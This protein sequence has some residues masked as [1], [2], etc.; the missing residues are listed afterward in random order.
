[1]LRELFI[2]SLAESFLVVNFRFYYEANRI[3]SLPMPNGHGELS[4]HGD[5]D[6]LTFFLGD[7]THCHFSQE[8][9]G[10]GKYSP[11]AEL[12]EEAIEFLRDLFSD[13][14]VFYR[15]RNGG[16]DGSIQCP[17]E[18]QFAKVMADCNCFVWSKLLGQ[19]ANA[20][21]GS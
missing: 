16:R 11:Q 14:V 21:F 4:I 20:K 2:R 9:L 19:D 1:M 12:I 17:S 15:A 7:I 6:E 3:A 13:K 5:A 10:G 8:C 18:Q